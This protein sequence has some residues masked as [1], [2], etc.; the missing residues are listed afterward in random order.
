MVRKVDD[1]DHDDEVVDHE[2]VGAD[3]RDEVHEVDRVLQIELPSEADR[4][5]DQMAD[6]PTAQ[7]LD[8]DDPV[9]IDGHPLR[10]F[11]HALLLGQLL[12][13]SD[14]DH[15]RKMAVLVLE[16]VLA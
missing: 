1:E 3:A 10:Q 2:D 8:L 4:T 5:W 7:N 9:G 14:D 6:R 11:L 13:R 15:A 16:S 12:V